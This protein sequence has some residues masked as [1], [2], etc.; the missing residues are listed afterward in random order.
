MGGECCAQREDEDPNRVYF[1]ELTV[2]PSGDA[3]RGCWKG[4]VMEGEG[5]YYYANDSRKRY[6]ILAKARSNSI[7]ARKSQT[8]VDGVGSTTA[9]HLMSFNGNNINSNMA[10]EPPLRSVQYTGNFH[11]N[12][13]HGV[14]IEH[15]SDCSLYE[16]EW[17]DDKRNGVGRMVSPGGIE[18]EGGWK[19]NLR[20][21]LGTLSYPGSTMGGGK[22]EIECQ[23][24]N[25]L[26]ASTGLLTYT[27]DQGQPHQEEVEYR[28]GRWQS[29]FGNSTEEG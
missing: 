1:K 8:K 20:H 11:N 23:W 26:P 10:G 9:A 22:T 16:G 29:Y 13:K 4:S 14:G 5:T 19:D 18:Y 15:Y 28:E 2:F 21:G 27:D 24:E 6:E 3:Y 17:L 7:S 25:D 12:K